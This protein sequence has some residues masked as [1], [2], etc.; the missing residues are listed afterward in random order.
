MTATSF[1]PC[2][3]QG[4]NQPDPP[5]NPPLSQFSVANG[6]G[7]GAAVGTGV[8][9]GVGTGVAVPGTGVGVSVAVGVDVGVAESGVGNGVG[10]TVG[11]GVKVGP[12]VGVGVGVTVG[13]G[14]GG[15]TPSCTVTDEPASRLTEVPSPSTTT[16]AWLPGRFSMPKTVGLTS[17][18]F[19]VA[20]PGI[21]AVNTSLSGTS[22]GP[23]ITLR[24]VE[25][26]LAF[27]TSPAVKVSE[28]PQTSKTTNACA[29]PLPVAQGEGKKPE[30]G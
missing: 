17:V 2:T 29:T 9:V 28:V 27:T 5:E 16:I 20:P 18:I 24:A 25:P 23:W 30:Y 14:V 6:E 3:D 1:P 21:V 4:F 22:T 15:G 11:N 8:G 7:V 12:G 19:A 26:H 13:P 10:V